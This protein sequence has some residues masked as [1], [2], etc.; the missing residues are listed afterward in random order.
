MNTVLI[1]IAGLVMLGVP[2]FMWW[3][4]SGRDLYRRRPLLLPTGW[5][6]AP[7]DDG[8]ILL[9]RVGGTKRGYVRRC[10]SS[11]WNTSRGVIEGDLI[12]AMR[13]VERELQALGWEGE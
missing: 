6:W 12:D 11:H 8:A 10:G 2:A 13:H 9:D 5:R 3:D 4:T 1:L 7:T